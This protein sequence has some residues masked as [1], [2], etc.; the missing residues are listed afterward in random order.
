MNASY[1]LL[2]WMVLGGFA[3]LILGRP[4]RS[5]A[6]VVILKDGSRL[7]GIV[8]T[9]TLVP[10]VILFSD[11][12]N[13]SLQVPRSKV[14]QII[15]EPESVGRLH[16]ARAL[17]H[18]GKYEQALEQIRDARRTAPDD[19]GLREEEEA[20]LRA[21]AIK[22]AK[23]TELKTGEYRGLL[24][25][26]RQAMDARQFEKALPWLALLE[27]DKV[28]ADARE[29]AT[30]LKITFYDRWG[31]SRADK[32]DNQ[33]AIE[34]YEKVMDLDPNARETYTKLMRLYEKFSQQGADAT[35]AQKLQEYLE[36]KVQE[37]PKD[38]DARLR[39]ANLL[40]LRKDWDGALQQYLAV[41]RD[42]TTSGSREVPLER[43]ETR[44]RAL[45]DGRHRKTAERR[46][47]DLAMQQFREF[48]S[49]FPDVDPTPL[50][51]YEYQKQL[52]GLSP[53]NDEGHMALARL[54]EKNGL[55]EYARKEVLTVLRNNP[56]HPEAL[57][58]LTTW[59]RADLAEIES[60][61][62]AGLY[63]QINGLVA[64]LHEN[65]PVERY[66]SLQPIH[67]TADD[68][69]EKAR[70]EML[71]HKRDD[72]QRA[73]DLADQGDQNFDRAM[74]ALDSYRNGADIGY[75][76]SEGRLPYQGGGTVTR[77]VGS[78]KADAIMYFER[79]LRFYREALA[80]DA[81][82]ADP[83]KKDL[84]RKIADCQRYLGMLK[85]QRIPRTPSGER[86]ARR[87]NV[88]QGGN[89]GYNPYLNSNPYGYSYGYPYSS[90]Y[91]Y[92]YS[93][94]YGY[95]YSNPYPYYPYPT[96]VPTPPTSK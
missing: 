17:A 81:S 31:D 94:P 4:T 87:Y 85:S 54:C 96:P 27:S 93:S 90:P 44:L 69:L 51:V 24:D 53:Q 11:H 68:F 46:D 7:E 36:A 40:Y 38:L 82:L 65:Y 66:P 64:Q 15:R 29:E 18:D 74:S 63:A 70:N 19:P 25:K 73:M 33:G 92:P 42:S 14:Q 43:V 48:Q 80:L 5:A 88:P 61:F 39:L 13:K 32:T 12:I 23:D 49:L 30:R 35:R 75:R 21:V 6:D 37:D 95:P 67:E 22:S 59:A 55:D 41:Y 57:R 34:C 78:H 58:I 83:A 71:A 1:G 76:S 28:P 8:T 62:N 72:S 86:S 56:N 89:Q 47:Y 26:I 84:R 20:V 79:A 91:G 50:T 9:S 45:L 16:I 60:A 77:F 10:D 3:A 52:A 2:R